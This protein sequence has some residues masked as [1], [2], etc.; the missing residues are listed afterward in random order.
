MFNSL[1]ILI[2]CHGDGLT[3]MADTLSWFFEE[4][5]NL[6]CMLQFPCSNL[7]SEVM[8]IIWLGFICNCLQSIAKYDVSSLILTILNDFPPLVDCS[9]VIVTSCPVWNTISVSVL[10]YS[11]P[12]QTLWEYKFNLSFTEYLILIHPHILLHLFLD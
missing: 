8:V 1:L 5:N 3:T 2:D 11:P 9:S 12:L 10:S 6:C 7:T 4:S